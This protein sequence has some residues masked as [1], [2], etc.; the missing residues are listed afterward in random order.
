MHGHV[1]LLQHGAKEVYIV[2]YEDSSGTIRTRYEF[3]PLLSERT[4]WELVLEADKN[5]KPYSNA[6]YRYW[7]WRAM[8]PI[9][10]QVWQVLKDTLDW[11]TPAKR[12]S[13]VD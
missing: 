6:S 8:E 3:G 1:L 11:F 5:G 13:N 2:T 12:H 9:R 10:A 4:L 7:A